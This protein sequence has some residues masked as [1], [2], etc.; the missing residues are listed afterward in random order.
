MRILKRETDLREETRALEQS[1][2]EL[3]ATNIIKQAEELAKVQL[4]LAR[5][6]AKV[7]DRIIAIPNGEQDYGNDIKRLTAAVE[8]MRDAQVLL[9]KGE[10]AVPTIAAETEAIELLKNS[11]KGGKQKGS[12]NGGNPSAGSRTG[13]DLESFVELLDSK[14]TDGLARPDRNTDL[15]SGNE[16][17]SVPSEF[18]SGLDRLY[19]AM[20]KNN[21]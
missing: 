9:E 17:D 6:T 20:E 10:T 16:T 19:E 12:G 8:A 21:N 11:K 15:S 5:R 13:A 2:A 7:V 14:P 4:D 1:R 18:R 3:A